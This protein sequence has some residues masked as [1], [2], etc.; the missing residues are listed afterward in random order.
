[1]KITGNYFNTQI[2]KKTTHKNSDA[3]KPSVKNFSQSMD[4]ITI[5][6]ASK[7]KIAE[8]RFIDSMRM[9]ISSE[10]TA[11][12]PAAELDSLAEQISRGEYEIDASN[13]AKKM[14]LTDLDI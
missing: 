3:D 13:V 14:L 10:I 2:N 1:M 8:S 6:H 4:S 11:E 9:K 5:S 12:T 7:D